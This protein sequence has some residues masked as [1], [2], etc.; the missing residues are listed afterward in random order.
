MEAFLQTL[1][2]SMLPEDSAFTIHSFRGK[3][4]LMKKLRDRLR[5]YAAWM[6]ESYRIVVV[7]DRDD[8]DCKILKEK[9]ETAATDSSLLTRTQT[10]GTPWQ[11]VNRIAIEE[12]GVP[13]VTAQNRT[14]SVVS[15]TP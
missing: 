1:L 5:G 6:P 9:L 12:L 10:G 7:V 3:P 11:V 13:T 8:D 15:R 4:D 14:L 2:A